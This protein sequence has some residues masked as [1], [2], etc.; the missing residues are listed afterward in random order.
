MVRLQKIIYLTVLHMQL[1]LFSE[2]K[3]MVELIGKLKT[4]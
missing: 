3:Q 1:L 4:G 2:W